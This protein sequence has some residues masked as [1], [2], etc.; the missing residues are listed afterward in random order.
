MGEQR[1]LEEQL[2]QTQRELEAD[3]GNVEKEYEQQYFK[4]QTE[5]L[6]NSD[7]EKYAKALDTQV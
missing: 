3:Y 7:L 1:Q 2:S 6:A 5:E 4:C